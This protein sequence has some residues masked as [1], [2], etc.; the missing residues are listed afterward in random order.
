MTS[1]ADYYTGL[2]EELGEYRSLVDTY[3][4]KTKQALTEMSNQSDANMK[5]HIGMLHTS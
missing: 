2:N 3:A 4:A 1:L 5:E